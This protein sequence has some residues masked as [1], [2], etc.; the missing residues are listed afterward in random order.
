MW[1]PELSCSSSSPGRSS[2]SLVPLG[3]CL[4]PGPL[5]SFSLGWQRG[6]RL[7]PMLPF[8][9]LPV[10]GGLRVPYCL[11]WGCKLI[12]APSP[13]VTRTWGKWRILGDRAS[14]D[15]SSLCYPGSLNLQLEPIP[16]SRGC[17][18]QMAELGARGV[19]LPPRSPSL[20]R[21]FSFSEIRLGHFTAASA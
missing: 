5:C 1:A 18:P 14:R 8:G 3:A 2:F 15:P 19:P 20:K 9:I 7:P 21:L 6:W 4:D 16:Q 17:P 10:L 12:L 11:L 13:S